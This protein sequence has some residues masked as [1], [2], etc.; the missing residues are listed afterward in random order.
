VAANSRLR[1]EILRI[2]GE[3]NIEVA[4]VVDIA[5]M[6]ALAGHLH[7]QRRGRPDCTL[8]PRTST[9]NVKDKGGPLSRPYSALSREGQRKG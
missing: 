6:I 4:C 7:S 2:C 3:R 8:N 5:A 9:G 1:K